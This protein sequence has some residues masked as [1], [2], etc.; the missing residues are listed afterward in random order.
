MCRRGGGV[1][2]ACTAQVL[3]GEVLQLYRVALPLSLGWPRESLCVFVCLQGKL[4]SPAQLPELMSVCDYVVVATP[5]TP[6]THQLVNAAAIAAMKPN[7]V[8]VNVGRGKCID[9]TALIQGEAAAW[10][11]GREKRVLGQQTWRGECSLSCC[12]QG[13]CCSLCDSTTTTSNLKWNTVF[14][15]LL[16]LW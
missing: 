1:T 5:Y 14:L 15:E 4:Y 13:Q 6:A 16:C 12:R 9:E 11:W 7:G 3:I 10:A 8:L 2:P